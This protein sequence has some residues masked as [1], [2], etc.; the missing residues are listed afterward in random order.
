MVKI[1]RDIKNLP[2]RPL[3]RL[4]QT[5]TIVRGNSTKKEYQEVYVVTGSK[6]ETHQVA[7]ET[8]RKITRKKISQAQLLGTKHNAVEQEGFSRSRA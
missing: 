6:R 3:K 4:Q 2:I 5:M 8:M 1:K 7:V